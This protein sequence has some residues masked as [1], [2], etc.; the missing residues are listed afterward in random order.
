[1]RLTRR[2]LYPFIVSITFIFFIVY[3]GNEFVY[4]KIDSK[5]SFGIDQLK[6]LE[7][8]GFDK[9]L[10]N[11][12]D[13]W[14]KQ[15]DIEKLNNKIVIVTFWASWCSPCV[16][17]FPSFELLAKESADVVI[18]AVSLDES[19]QEALNFLKSMK[20]TS[21]SV[22]FIFIHDEDK[23]L[24]KHFGVLRLPE[25]FIFSK[26][27]KFQKKIIGINDWMSNSTLT[28]LKKLR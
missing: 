11:R 14:E 19:K 21:Q 20:L 28:Y 6:S 18:V 16:E 5:Y 2:H 23:I 15:V 27:K 24:S 10:F 17:E 13:I 26:D 7:F 4:K 8:A 12:S 22:N 25:S 9:N 3:L 1:M